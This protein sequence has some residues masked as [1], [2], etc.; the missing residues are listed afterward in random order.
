MNLKKIKIISVIGTF[1][2][3]FL[4]HFLYDI[5][6]N[7][8]FSIFFP[9]NESIWEHMKMLF[10]TILLFSFIEYILLNKFNIKYN[11]FIFSSFIK[12]L[13]SIPIYLVMFLPYYYRFGENMIVIFI[14]M[15]IT[16]IIVEFISYKIYSLNNIEYLNKISII[17]II[18]C[19]IIFGYL[20]YNPIKT[21]LFLDTENEKYGINIYNI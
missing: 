19:Y 3:C 1:L 17:L 5:F 10:T 8:L 15:L 13:L 16:F 11:N 7:S 2:L 21:H 18:I 14:I 4:T 12:A 9:V 20:T 6:P